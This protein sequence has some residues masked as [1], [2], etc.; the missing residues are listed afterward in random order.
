MNHKMEREMLKLSLN[1]PVLALNR[2]CVSNAQMS[3]GGFRRNSY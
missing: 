1:P 2:S 3:I